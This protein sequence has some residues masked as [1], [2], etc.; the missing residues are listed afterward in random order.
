VGSSICDDVN[1]LRWWRRIS[2]SDSYFNAG[3]NTD[4]DAKPHS[5][6]DANSYTNADSNPN[7]HSNPNADS[8]TDRTH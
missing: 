5:Y 6:A 8:G 1:G 7:S 3:S 4:S 2:L